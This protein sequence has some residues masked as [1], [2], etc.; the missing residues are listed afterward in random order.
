[1]FFFEKPVVFTIIQITMIIVKP[2]KYKLSDPFRPEDTSKLSESIIMYFK[3][4]HIFLGIDLG[5]F[6]YQN[7]QVKYA[8]RLIS[9][10]QPLA[11]YGLC[12]YALLKIIANTEF[13]WYTISFTEYVAMSVAI[14][15]FSNEMTYCNFMINLKFID[16]KLKIGDVSFRIGVKLI[17]ST[18]LIGVTRCFTTTTYCLLGFC[19]KPTAAQILFQIPWLT[20]DLMLLQYM[21]I[22]YACYCRLVKILGILK[23]RNTDIE[24]MRRIY[25]TLVDV[26]DR[27]RAP[28]DLAYLL[29]LL[30]SIPDV[31][32]SIYESIIKV[33]EINTA[34]AL[35]MSII[36][37]TNI[38]SLALMFAPVL[39][40]GFL[41]SLTMKMRIIL[42]DKLLEEQDKKTYR[43]IVLFIKY[44]ETCPLKLKACQII[45]LDFSFPIIILN[46]VVTYLIVAI[47][48]THFL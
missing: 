7:R 11:I 2:A 3:I 34:K 26:L 45:P 39:T 8:V 40:A 29:G 23:K 36:Y 44:I 31:L 6:R 4:F 10:I 16:T 38:Q 22:F 25:K 24:E 43:H 21:F 27:A 5:G 48:L 41:P 42:H 33:G 47:Q 12:I 14:T 28:F 9:L 30:F 32:Y 13:L 18:I 1:M 15:L 46:I 17:S 20:I 19:A 35:S 37:I